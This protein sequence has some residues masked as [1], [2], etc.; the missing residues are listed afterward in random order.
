MNVLIYELKSKLQYIVEELKK[1]QDI[2]IYFAFN[3]DEFEDI[4]NKIHPEII[5][6][7]TTKF[8]KNALLLECSNKFIYILSHELSKLTITD[9]NTNQE[10]KIKQIFR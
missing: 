3:D 1:I 5:F 6:I 2:S 8:I 10:V 9:N 4:S 7:E